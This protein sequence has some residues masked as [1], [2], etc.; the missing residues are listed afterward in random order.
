M[1]LLAV[2][3]NDT[4]MTVD[5]MDAPVTITIAAG[6]GKN[7][8][9][10][11]SSL[12]VS[13]AWWTY[14]LT[15][16]DGGNGSGQVATETRMT[17]SSVTGRVAFG[18]WKAEVFG[19]RDSSCTELVYTGS[20]TGRVTKTGGTISVTAGPV[21]DASL[22]RALDGRTP[23]AT[24]D[25]VL[26]P[27]GVEGDPTGSILGTV[28]W[29]VDG[30]AVASWTMNSG[31]WQDD[32]TGEEIP[33]TG[34]I[35]ET[36]PGEGKT[37][38]LEVLDG[39]GSLLAREGWENAVL[40]L[41]CTYMISGHVT[42]KTT[43]VEISVS[44]IQLPT[45]AVA[46]VDKTVVINSLL[47][48]NP[49]GD[50]IA[51][52]NVFV[53]GYRRQGTGKA[54]NTTDLSN[55]ITFPYVTYC[56]SGEKAEYTN[57]ELGLE[58]IYITSMDELNTS[59]A[60][61]AWV[62]NYARL[63]SGSTENHT[64]ERVRYSDKAFTVYSY[65]LR[66]CK[67]LRE[68]T[69]SQKINTIYSNA[70][71]NCSSLERVI[72]T[73]KVSSIN[74]RAF[75]GCS[76]L[77]SIDFPNLS[78][79]GNYAFEN[80][81]SLESFDLSAKCTTPGTY[82]FSGCS[83]LK[84]VT[85]HEGLQTLSHN[86]FMNCTSLNDVVIPDTVTA[87]GGYVFAYCSSLEGIT[88][89][90]S[91]TSTGSNTF[92]GSGLKT[93]TVPSSI[94]VL[95]NYVFAECK[96]LTEV[97]LSDG[98]SMISSSAFKGCESL[99]EIIIP[100][101]VTS[102]ST[103]VFGDC[104][105][106][107]RVKLP[108]GLTEI[109]DWTFNGCTALKTFDVPQGIETIGYNSF[110]ECSSLE[111]FNIPETVTGIKKNAFE[112]CT[113]LTEI[114]IPQSVV[115]IDDYLFSGCSSLRQVTFPDNVQSFGNHGMFKGCTSLE[116][117]ELPA[118]A[119][120]LGKSFFQGC[121]SLVSVTLPKTITSINISNN[122]ASF[123]DCN[124][125]NA[126]IFRGTLEEWYAIDYP[127]GADIN[128]FCSDQTM[129]FRRESG[130]P[131]TISGITPYGRTF[132]T[133]NIPE[134]YTR[135]YGSCFKDFTWL[136][137]IT[138][139]KGVTEIFYNTFNGCTALTEVNLPEGLEK[140][141]GSAFMGCTSLNNVTLPDGLISLGDSVFR[142]C[143]S[144]Q[145]IR[146]PESL[147]ITGFYCFR[148]CTALRE[149]S[150]PG[151]LTEIRQGA[152]EGCTSLESIVIPEGITEI[153]HN[154]FTNCSSLSSITLP[155]SL[156]YIG[157]DCFSS[158]TELKTL[159]IPSA[160]TKIDQRALASSGVTTLMIDKEKNSLD[161]SMTRYYGTVLWKGEF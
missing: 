19:Y 88:I 58:P 156:T 15:P 22:A 161:L 95:N 59:G 121:T 83:S 72:N 74:Q 79:L 5:G 14:T 101:S 151:S 73:E 132:S 105:S 43:G 26:M 93:I 3:C 55:A 102:F 76:S 66:N 134:G 155:Q 136:T 109:P 160:V 53:V 115:S 89:P 70:F 45:A 97:N 41:N 124:V 131:G 61:E 98:I 143:T 28:T 80:C 47:E 144:L 35:I 111:T 106:L 38:S 30:T 6:Q 150:L 147:T 81:T 13:E 54:V 17:G 146:I 91:V 154:A 148:E 82:I 68:V 119:T 34:V 33:D 141:Y 18:L 71:E 40:A 65:A 108:S 112:N 10:T 32:R 128:V 36:A 139:P 7:V 67:A 20:G 158:C 130:N 107:V 2:S 60:T 159:L 29:S 37:I 110:S 78:Y 129:V 51:N 77:I 145:N 42:P 100:D 122:Y 114:T 62:C 16:A 63:G 90:D 120:T 27:V 75:A 12:P 11:G 8:S 138:I 85:L 52:S 49:S 23:K 137:G 116:S 44:V 127:T 96:S 142:G 133:L 157:M 153:N 25:L 117:V 48:I 24:S 99:T 149:I 4:P 126:I 50:P 125:L 31:T 87:I 39:N 9:M 57:A 21:T 94:T 118:G 46:S 152:F 135:I 84:T 113:S 1:M 92:Y 140:I 69:L 56:P 64:L 123:K 104:T 86:F 103:R